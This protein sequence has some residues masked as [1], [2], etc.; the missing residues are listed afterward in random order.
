MTF[1]GNINDL[2]FRFAQ[3]IMDIIICCNMYKLKHSSSILLEI[4]AIDIATKNMSLPK[5]KMVKKNWDYQKNASIRASPFTSEHH[6]LGIMFS[7]TSEDGISELLKIQSVINIFTS[8]LR[9]NT[10]L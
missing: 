3:G 6:V 8:L 10:T 5:S 7:L 4:V 2:I 9:K 1:S